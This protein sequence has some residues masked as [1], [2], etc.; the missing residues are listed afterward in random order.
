MISKEK[1]EKIVKIIIEKYSPEKIIL[2]GSY[3]NGNPTEDS[4]VDFLIVKDTELPRYKRSREIRKYLRGLKAPIDL[5]V[6][7]RDEIEEWKN[8]KNAFITQIVKNGKV[9]YEKQI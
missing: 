1:I 2:F 4:D 6:Y 9:M 7:N 5:I 3:A 8:V